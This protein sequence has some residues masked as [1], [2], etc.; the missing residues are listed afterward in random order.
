[1]DKLLPIF[2]LNGQVRRNDIV[3]LVITIVIYVVAGAILGAVVNLLLGWFALLKNIICTLMGIYML[4]G[5]VLSIW[6]FIK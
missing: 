6:T 4:V 5:I 3:S 2:P 1:M